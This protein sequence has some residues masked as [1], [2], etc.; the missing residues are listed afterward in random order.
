MSTER[1]II[2][3]LRDYRAFHANYGG[4]RPLDETHV[5]E[6]A[7]GPA[8]LI[9]TGAG[10]EKRDIESLK[11]S[12]KKLDHALEILNEMDWRA[13][14][15]LNDPYLSDIADYSVI[16]DWRTK[17]QALDKENEAIR[18]ENERLKKKGRPPSKTERVALVFPRLQLERH[19]RAIKSLAKYLRNVDLHVVHPKLMS[20]REEAAGESA[21][22]QV[23]ATFQRLRVS[24][25]REEVAAE[26]T[27]EMFGISKDEVERIVEFRADVKLASCAEPE[28]GRTVYQQ[29]MCQ[30]H[31]QREWRA[32]KSKAS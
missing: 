15:S 28:C 26:Q 12:Y 30:K 10:F 21:N 4:A 24:G 19:D 5:S 11:A 9:T 23:Y 6:A 20:R 27:A 25:L 7:Y 17:I 13:W 31:Y 18:R 14:M 1:D 32:R 2:Q 8:G 22:A 16:E 29:N 3:L